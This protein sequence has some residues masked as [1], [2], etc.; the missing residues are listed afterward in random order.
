MSGSSESSRTRAG[1]RALGQAAQ[2]HAVEVEAEAQADVTH[3]DA[4]TQAT[5]PTEV[6]VEL[7]GEGA[8]EHVEARRALDR[9]EPG[10]AL[11]R[12]VDLVGGLLLG[13]GPRVAHGGGRDVVGDEALRPRDELAPRGAR[14]SRRARGRAAARA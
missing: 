5:D 3:Q 10:Q 8:A 11:Q 9:V 4:V 7:E 2:E 14:R 13:L 1:K 6:V 12:G